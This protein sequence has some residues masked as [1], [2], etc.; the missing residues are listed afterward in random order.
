MARWKTKVS[1]PEP[2]P[3]LPELKHCPFCGG[4]A[5]VNGFGVHCSTPG[6]YCFDG[7]CTSFDN[8]EQMV[9]AWNRRVIVYEKTNEKQLELF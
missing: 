7:S 1:K 8:L 5:E 9:D 3:P 4:N 2:K 6:C